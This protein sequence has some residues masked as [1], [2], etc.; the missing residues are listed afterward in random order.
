MSGAGAPSGEAVTLES[1]QAELRR[2]AAEDLGAL[3][4]RLERLLQDP[5]L[6]RAAA[7]QSV[8]QSLP[9]RATSPTAW[10]RATPPPSPRGEAAGEEALSPARRT[11][12]RVSTWGRQVSPAGEQVPWSRTS[13][14]AWSSVPQTSSGPRLHEHPECL[15][16]PRCRGS[17][18]RAPPTAE[19]AWR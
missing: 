19:R 10:A 15:S 1:L 16:P 13:G 5:E 17:D 14:R 18:S 8:A 3:G 12:A 9:S 2:F 11:R 6:R 7:R 4:D